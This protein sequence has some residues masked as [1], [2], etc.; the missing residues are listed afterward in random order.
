MQLSLIQLWDVATAEELLT[1]EADCNSLCFSPDGKALAT[2]SAAGPAPGPTE[3][4]I[5]LAAEDD[6]EPAQGQ[7]NRSRGRT[8]GIIMWR[9]S[10]ADSTKNDLA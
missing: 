3:V 1:L 9:G 4:R 2:T 5:W 10:S 7:T 6:P 8:A